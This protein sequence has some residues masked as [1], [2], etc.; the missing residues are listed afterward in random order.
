MTEKGS[1]PVAIIQARLE[2]T[3]LPGKMMM[4]LSGKPIIDRVIE[5]ALEIKKIKTVVVATTV[6]SADSQLVKQADNL[7]IKSFRGSVED[8]LD[9]FYHAAME[10]GADPIVRICADSPLIDSGFMDE[11]IEAH[12]KSGAD[13]TCCSSGAPLGAVGEIISLAAL[14]EMN[15]TADKSYQREHV[16]P[17]I[18]ENRRSFK[19]CEVEA[20][21]WMRFNCRL[22]IDEEL[23]Y[24]MFTALYHELRSSKL[25]YNLKNALDLL[26]RRP[27]IL[28]INESVRQKD[29]R[30]ESS[31]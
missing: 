4:E 10:Y 22:T 20:P 23:D 26:K 1:N 5:N 8:V 25:M 29:W 19:V 27:D 16:T 24:K 7:G 2:S 17:Y 3:R 30:K 15:L 11:M 18:Y 12:I 31:P 14:T 13:Y 9:R 6:N 28:K 21:G